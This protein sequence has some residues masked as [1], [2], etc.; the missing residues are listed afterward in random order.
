MFFFVI[1]STFDA[2]QTFHREFW[3]ELG[4]IGY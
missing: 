1:H 3:N 2:S 4:V